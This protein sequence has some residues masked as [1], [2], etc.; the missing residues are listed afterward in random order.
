MAAGGKMWTHRQG[1]GDVGVSPIAEMVVSIGAGNH[2][3]VDIAA[4]T[5]LKG[6]VALLYDGAERGLDVDHVA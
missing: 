2:A 6:D 3:S 1:N 4:Q 5:Q